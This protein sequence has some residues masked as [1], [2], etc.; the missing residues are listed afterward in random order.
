ME[1]ELAPPPPENCGGPWDYEELL[2]I[3]KNP[4]CEDHNDR[5]EWLEDC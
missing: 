1:R 2:D 4:S 3:I 5:M